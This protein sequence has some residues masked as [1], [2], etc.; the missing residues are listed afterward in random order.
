MPRAPDDPLERS[1]DAIVVG[2][3]LGGLSAAAGLAR[4]GLRVA[5]LEQHVVAGGYAHRFL[6]KARRSGRVY[7]FD[8]A[9]HM[10]GDLRGDR[11]LGRRLEALGVLPRLVLH[12]FDDAYHAR[13]PAHDLRIPAD[14][15][16]YEALLCRTFPGE[17]RGI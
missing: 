17:A 15:A 5:V 14:A 3:G 2:A 13:G 4:A 8:V 11:W 9:L 6:R 7:D 10:T 1:W 16:A 12:H